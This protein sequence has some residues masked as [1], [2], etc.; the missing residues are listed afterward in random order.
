LKKTLK[1]SRGQ[2]ASRWI[3]DIEPKYL[4]ERFLLFYVLA[5]LGW[6]RHAGKMQ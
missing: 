3:Q 5:I 4:E 6:A 2:K 1:L